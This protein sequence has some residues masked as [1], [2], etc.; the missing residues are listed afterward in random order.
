VIYHVI[1]RGN[2]RQRIFHKP[3][4]YAAFVA[5]LLWVIER[6]P[7]RIL[8]FCLM[9]NHWHLVLWPRKD[10]DLSRFMLRLTTTHVARYHSHYHQRARG[11]LYQGR[12][13]SFPVEADEYFLA[14]MRYVESNAVR[15]GMVKRARDWRWSSFARRRGAKDELL[16]DWPVDRPGGWE[17]LLDDP[18]DKKTLEAIRENVKRG[19]PLG[20]AEWVQRMAK[21]LGL[22]FTLRGRG[23]PQKRRK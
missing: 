13:K 7:M 3:Q 5:L 6:V 18:M 14:L 22:E 21:K 10:G 23:R 19:R 8:G 20:S 12:F 2:G 9:P 17:A 15:A 11:H 4:D 16:H 1:N